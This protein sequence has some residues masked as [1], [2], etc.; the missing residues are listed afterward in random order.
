MRD[1]PA[2]LPIKPPVVILT[3]PRLILRTTT[4]GDIPVL[5]ERI[6]GDSDVMRYAFMGVPME[7]HRAEAFMRKF[8]TFGETLTEMAILTER[9]SGE[10]IGIA[11]LFSC[12]VLGAADFEIGFLLARPF[13]GRGIATEIGHAQ[14]AFGF[15]RLKCARLLGLVNPRNTASIHALTKLGMHY[16]KDVA[17]DDRPPRA[18]Y[19][20]EA[21]AWRQRQAE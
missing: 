20:I 1:E 21:E 6:F 9:S 7:K 19:L 11:G 4:E 8:F 16:L 15:D 5:Q 18:V 14:L 2:S 17:P 12:D 3:T 13:W 10:V